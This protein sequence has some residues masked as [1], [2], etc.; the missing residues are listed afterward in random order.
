MILRVTWNQ[1]FEK[2]CRY[3]TG[4]QMLSSKSLFDFSVR[5]RRV[6]N[7]RRKHDFRNAF[8]FSLLYMGQMFLYTP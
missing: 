2:V 3:F 6:Q 8:H 4:R 7:A 1:L 5:F